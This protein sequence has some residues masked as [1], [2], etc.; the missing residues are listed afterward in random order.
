MKNPNVTK[1]RITVSSGRR[2]YCHFESPELF[3][4]DSNSAGMSSKSILV[5][6][7]LRET[8]VNFR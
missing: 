8:G 2:T 4:G 6:K 3:F 7:N 5:L 1:A